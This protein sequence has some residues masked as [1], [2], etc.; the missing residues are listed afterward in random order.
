M[1]KAIFVDIS[2][3]ASS[4]S[5]TSMVSL[6]D[7][8]KSAKLPSNLTPSQA[9]SV[10]DQ[11][12]QKAINT[13]SIRD[14]LLTNL[15]QNSDGSYGWRVNVDALHKNFLNNI[16]KFPADGLKLKFSGPVLF[17]GGAQS[18]YLR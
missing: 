17:I 10:V 1:E 2:P 11:H 4:P 8:M 13:R 9:R 3:I 5:L 12:L 15:V 18:D 16:A 7:S 6:F 14:F